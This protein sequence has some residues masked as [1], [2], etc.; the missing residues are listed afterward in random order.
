ML[1]FFFEPLLLIAQEDTSYAV[2]TSDNVHQLQL[3]H[4]QGYGKVAD[5]QWVADGSYFVVGVT[6]G[7]LIYDP[8]DWT[9]LPQLIPS[10]HGRVWSMAASPTESLVATGNN[11]GTISLWDISTQQEI[12]VLRGH[13]RP[14]MD[15]NFNAE[16]TLL[17][18]TSGDPTQ[19]MAYP[20]ADEKSVRLW[21]MN[22]QNEI[23]RYSVKSDNM[24]GIVSYRSVLSRDSHYLAIVGGE[25]Y[26]SHVALPAS[27]IY[28]LQTGDYQFTDYAHFVDFFSTKNWL[29][30]VYDESFDVIDVENN[31]IITE[32]DDEEIR[33][34][35]LSEND[36]LLNH[37]DSQLLLTGEGAHRRHPI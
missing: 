31:K 6:A 29:V 11:N 26:A 17:V 37:D 5:A 14:V 3:I 16:G 30:R 24:W 1:S 7:I 18:S 21:D 36:I 2:I 35:D 13:L 33:F 15:I 20:R 12:A 23:G 28:N 4:S 32:Q 25:P 27:T 10:Q 19:D 34:D 8:A 22:T 9:A